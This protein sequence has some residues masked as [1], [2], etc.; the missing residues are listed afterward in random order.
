MTIIPALLGQA[1][2]E[3]A[4]IGREDVTLR[5][6]LKASETARQALSSYALTEPFANTIGL[7]TI[8]LGAAVS[9]LN[10]LNWHLTR[11]TRWAL[12]RDASVASDEWLSRAA[13]EAI[14]A[15]ETT[16]ADTASHLLVFG[17][18]DSASGPDRLLEPL[19][20]RRTDG[21]YPTYDLHDVT[22]TLVVRITAAEFDGS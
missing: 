11:Y 13:A 14:R 21:E 2:P 1:V 9:L 16:P 6:T 8:S 19:Y 15:G 18:E 17:I 10:D 22:D 7:E 12:V 4:L 3:V 5:E 20:V